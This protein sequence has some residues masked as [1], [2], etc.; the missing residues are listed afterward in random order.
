MR[1]TVHASVYWVDINTN[2]KNTVKQCAICM[3][4]QQ[5]QPHEKTI[6]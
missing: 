5:T 6:P 1:L 3:E 4:Y 2:I